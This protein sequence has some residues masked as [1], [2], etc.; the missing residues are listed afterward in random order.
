MIIELNSDL[1][2]GFSD[3]QMDIAAS[4]IHQ[5]IEVHI[6]NNVLSNQKVLNMMATFVSQVGAS[7]KAN[8]IIAEMEATISLRRQ[9]ANRL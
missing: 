3:L 8:K 7:N 4:L 9:D 1:V 6:F 5:G 2:I